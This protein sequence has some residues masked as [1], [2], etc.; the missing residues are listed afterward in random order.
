MNPDEPI[1]FHI[2]R[3]TKISDAMV[4][5]APRIDKVLP[6]FLEFCRGAALVAHNAS[7]DVSFIS[8]NAAG[9]GLEFDPTV[10]DTVSL[11]RVLLPQLN[12]YKLDVV[13]KALNISLENHHR[14]VE[15]AQATA[16]IFVA[17]LKMLKQRSMKSLD[18]LNR[19]GQLDA[20]E[21]RRRPPTM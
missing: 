8:H 14:A 20:E 17:F 12:R 21:S 18:E 5:D 10:L 16:E 15:D 11:A 4:L 3:L 2:E 13:A 19:L 1:P 9:L 7:F 6:E